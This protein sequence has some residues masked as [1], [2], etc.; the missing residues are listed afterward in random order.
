MNKKKLILGIILG[1][2]L[3]SGTTYAIYTWAA[4]LMVEGRTECFRV[5]Y[6]KGQDIGSD[7]E[8][9]ILMMSNDYTGGLYS[10]VVVNIDSKCTIDNGIGT[11]YLNTDTITSSILLTSGALKYQVIENSLTKPASGTITS[12]G[13]VA[14]YDNI[15]VTNNPKQLSVSVWLD[16]SMIT[17]SNR[18][19]ILSSVYKGSISMKVE[20]GDKE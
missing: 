1:I 8:S 17:D 9:K 10:S 16:S 7:S 5:N 14:I 3:I 20:S 19:E 18:D 11:L 12:T 4:S 2:I 6:I 15:E 13:K